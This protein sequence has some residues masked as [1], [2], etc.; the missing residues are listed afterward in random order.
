MKYL[1]LW[2]SNPAKLEAELNMYAEHGYRLHS[3]RYIKDGGDM[4]YV[5]VMARHK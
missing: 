4:P 1:T 2:A 3:W 5:A